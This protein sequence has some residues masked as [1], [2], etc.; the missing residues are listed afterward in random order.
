MYSIDFL[1]SL[2]LSENEWLTNGKLIPSQDNDSTPP[3]LRPSESSHHY[4]PRD[5]LNCVYTSDNEHFCSKKGFPVEEPQKP[6][7]CDHFTRLKCK[8]CDFLENGKI[9]V[10]HDGQEPTSP[11]SECLYDIREFM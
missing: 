7:D 4:P 3:A 2:Q 10:A 9:C 1:Q 8:D 11:E 5:C 6:C